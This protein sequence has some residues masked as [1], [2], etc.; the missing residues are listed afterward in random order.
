MSIEDA[1]HQEPGSPGPAR[2]QAGEAGQGHAGDEASSVRDAQPNQGGGDLL[3][4]AL[5]R[6]N[7]A[8]AWQRVKANKGSAGVDG[9]TVLDTG[10]YLK[11]AWPEIRQ[12]LLDGSY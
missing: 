2:T 3:G 10:E 11:L 5:S 6:E 8:R 4:Q 12:R 7:M 1:M 9:R